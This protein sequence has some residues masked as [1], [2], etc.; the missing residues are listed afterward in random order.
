MKDAIN[1]KIELCHELSTKRNE[2]MQPLYDLFSM[3]EQDDFEEV[4]TLASHM[5][6]EGTDEEREAYHTYFEAMRRVIEIEIPKNDPFMFEEVSDE[7]IA[8]AWDEMTEALKAWI[9]ATSP[10]VEAVLAIYQRA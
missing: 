2:L 10:F 7:E 6:K 3:H 4:Y 8:C 1:K 5:N 9:S